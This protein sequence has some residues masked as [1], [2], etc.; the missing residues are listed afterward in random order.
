MFCLRKTVFNKCTFH[1]TVVLFS[2]ESILSSSYIIFYIIQFYTHSHLSFT[3]LYCREVSSGNAFIILLRETSLQVFQKLTATSNL[4]F[5]LQKVHSNYLVE[6]IQSINFN[7]INDATHCKLLLTSVSHLMCYNCKNCN[8]IS[9]R[10]RVLKYGDEVSVE[11]QVL[12]SMFY[13]F[14][15]RLKI[16]IF[17]TKT[18]LR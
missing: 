16:I 8:V 18:S 6:S 1:F 4:N 9:K 7:V 3:L 11:E 10:P 13:V 15:V 12:L 17:V 14:E 5:K 2:Q